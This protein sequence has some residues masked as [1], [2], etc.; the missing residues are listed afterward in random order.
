MDPSFIERKDLRSRN[1]QK[2][3]RVRNDNELRA[4]PGASVN[5]QKQRQLSLR[6]QGC[7]RLIQQIQAVRPEVVLCKCQKALPV[8][9]LMVVLR[10]TAGSAAVFIFLRGN[11]VKT[12][13][14][15]KI[16]I[17]SQGFPLTIASEPR[18]RPGS[19][20]ALCKRRCAE[21][22]SADVFR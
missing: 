20:A 13:R 18:H 5:F 15:Q 8:R 9:F 17:W 4:L 3:R 12:F 2:D 19:A 1:P 16:G 21:E 6:R 11:I 10:N 14:T 7:L 22:E